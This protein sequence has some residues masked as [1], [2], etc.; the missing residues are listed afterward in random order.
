MK[1]SVCIVSLGCPKNLVDSEV[2]AAGFVRR[3]LRLVSTPGKADLVVVTTCA[4]IRSAVKESEDTIRR[5]VRKKKVGQQIVVAGCL[6]QRYGSRLRRRLAGVD[7]FVPISEMSSLPTRHVTDPAC[8]PGLGRESVPCLSFPRLISTPRHFAY[9][10]IA[11]GC[12][13]NCSYCLIPTLRGPLRSRPM[14][15][16]LEEARWLAR[17]GVK[18]LILVAQDTTAY[19]LDLSRR[20][21]LPDLLSRLSRIRAI[22]WLRLMYA[23]PARISNELLCEFKENKKLCRYLD[24][25]LQHISDRVLRRMNRPYG[26]QEVEQILVQLR[27][28]PGM[29]LRTTFITGFPGETETEFYELLQFVREARF[30]RLG[31]FAYSPERG[32]RA[33]GLSDHV[34][35]RVRESRRRTLMRLQAQISRA[36]LSNLRGR[37][38]TVIVDRPGLGRTPYDAPEIDGVVKLGG[39]AVT[40]GSIVRARVTHTTTHDLYAIVS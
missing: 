21:L 8:R 37:T 32:T 3:G 18:E 31:V 24:M 27:S 20:S 9:L 35:T 26:R 2:L 36:L 5:L 33:V 28:I 14:E 23:H 17:C 30:E 38:I 13:N 29:H 39:R 25:P 4:F 40:S 12:G 16:I 10:K 22:R 19:G 7:L 11:E 6:V 1:S 15:E 34:P